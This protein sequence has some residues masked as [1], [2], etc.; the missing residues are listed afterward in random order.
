MEM[1]IGTI[2]TIVLLVTVLILGLIL[3]RSIFT[4]GTN[5]VDKIGEKVNSQIDE[6]FSNDENLRMAIY[7][8]DYKLKIKQGTQGQGFAISLQNVNLEA[9]AF[10]YELSVDG[11]FDIQDK[12]KIS[13]TSAEAWLLAK[14]GEINL[15]GSQRMQIPELILFTIPEAAPKCTIPY[16][17]DVYD[18]GTL[19]TSGKVFVTIV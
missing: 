18:A 8:S 2:V 15:A 13:K 10:T 14:R 3:V 6:L 12:C 16:K 9:K 1:S 11:L 7:P 4:A 19:Y 5:S 17:I